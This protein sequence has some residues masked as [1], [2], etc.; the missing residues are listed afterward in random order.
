MFSRLALHALLN[1]PGRALPSPSLSVPEA[2]VS[3]AILPPNHHVHMTAPMRFDGT[4][5]D[6]RV[7]L[8]QVGIHFDLNPGMCPSD[9]SKVGFLINHLSDKA[10]EWATPL[11]ENKK[12]IIYDYEMFVSELCHTF[13]PTRRSQMA[14]SIAEERDYAFTVLAG[15]ISGINVPGDLEA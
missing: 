12:P 8:I 14:E 3:A 2:T 11:W 1:Q 9:K 5:S 6:C 7:F 4:P 13:N 10:L 15:G